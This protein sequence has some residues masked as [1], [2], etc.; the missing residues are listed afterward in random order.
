MK[1]IIKKNTDNTKNVMLQ[2]KVP[3][4]KIAQGLDLEINLC[5]TV[6]LS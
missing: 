2:Q 4:E 5:L 1:Q 3:R 6:T